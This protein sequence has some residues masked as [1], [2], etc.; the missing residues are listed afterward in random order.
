MYDAPIADF[1]LAR[2]RSG[3]IWGRTLATLF[4]R[5]RAQPETG[6]MPVPPGLPRAYVFSDRKGGGE[7]ER[8]SVFALCT[9]HGYL[10]DDLDDSGDTSRDLF[11]AIA[12]LHALDV[13][14]QEDRPVDRM[15]AQP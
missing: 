1:S 7:G 3:V 8:R 12:V 14:A 9:G 4:A 10:I 6:K 11:G 13:T 15:H 5:P 2:G